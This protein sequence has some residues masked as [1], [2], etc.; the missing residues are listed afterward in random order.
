MANLNARQ[1]GAIREKD[2]LT[3]R[4]PGTHIGSLLEIPKGPVESISPSHFG[5]FH[6]P[7]PPKAPKPPGIR[8]RKYYGEL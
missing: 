2:K 5:Q 4:G 7:K 6:G 1:L 3:G 8:R